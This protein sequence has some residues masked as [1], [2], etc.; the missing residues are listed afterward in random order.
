MDSQICRE[1]P[2]HSGITR[3][4]KRCRV[5]LGLLGLVQGGFSEEG[6]FELKPGGWG[7]WV[8]WQE[9][10]SRQREQHGSV[11]R[12]NCS[13]WCWRALRVQWWGWR[14]KWRPVWERTWAWPAGLTG[15][16]CRVFRRTFMAL[17]L[18]SVKSTLVAVGELTGRSKSGW[19]DQLG[20]SCHP[21]DERR[22]CY[23]AD[24]QTDGFEM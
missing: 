17:S 20:R 14:G 10:H 11:G 22:W 16:T 21:T 6:T 24:V 7:N 19:E 8:K 4:K 5:L 23:Q 18:G 12:R 15:S 9:E 1:I 13:P 3:I 2:L